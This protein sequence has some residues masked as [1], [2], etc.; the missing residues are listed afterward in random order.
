[1]AKYVCSVC[2]YIYD[3]AA[4]DPQSSVAPGTAWENLPSDWVCPLCTAEKSEF[5]KQDKAPSP[6]K[7]AVPVYEAH[8]DD[9]RE[10]SALEIAALCTNLAR[11]CEKQ[12]KLE[13]E[14]LFRKLADYYKSIAS[15]LKSA[16]FEQLLALVEKDLIEGFAAANGAAKND[17]D[18]GAQRALVWSEKVTRI[19]KSLLSR[20]KKEGDDMLSGTGVYVCTICGFIYVGNNLPDV[21]PVCK[22]PNW[23]FEKVEG[24]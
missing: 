9:M 2:G 1:M 22:V 24:R 6:A 18:R 23:K 15:P 19:L 13:E 3:E 20:Y 4:G 10:M 12:Y 14:A 11:G 16:D 17:G 8:D 21:C 5:Y 7:K